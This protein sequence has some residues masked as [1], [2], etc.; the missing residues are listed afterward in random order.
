MKSFAVILSGCGVYDGSE[1]HEAVLTMLALDNNQCHYEIFAPDIPQYSAKNHLTGQDMPEDRNVLIE[2]ARI[3]RGKIQSLDKLVQ[4]DFDG[5]VFPGGFGVAKNL[6]SYAFD[7]VD[8][9]VNAEVD[10]VIKEFHSAH[11]PIGGLCIAPVLLAKVLVDI[12]V[13]IGRDD[14]TASNIKQMGAKH[15][16]S[17]HGIAVVDEKNKVV[18]APCYMLDA[19]LSQIYSDTEAVVRAMLKLC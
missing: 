12:E 7:G 14:N 17:K 15:I 1:I 2:S 5:I 8:C 18:T 3:A 19:G 16:E 11:K 4:D 9:I 6:C 10:R 13:T